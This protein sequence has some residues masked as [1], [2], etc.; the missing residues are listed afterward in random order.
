MSDWSR[1]SIAALAVICTVAHS[2]MAAAAPEPVRALVWRCLP[3]IGSTSGTESAFGEIPAKRGT[4]L[5]FAYATRSAADDSDK[6][7]VATATTRVEICWA[8]QGVFTCPGLDFPVAFVA[9]AERSRSRCAQ[10]SG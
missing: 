10:T 9:L 1:H 8:R 7:R 5:W 4:T 6:S 2:S 3:E